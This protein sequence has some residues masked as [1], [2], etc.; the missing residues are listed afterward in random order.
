MRRTILATAIVFALLLGAPARATDVSGDQS[1]LWTLAGSPYLMVGDVR[2]PPGETL[3][4]EAGVEVIARG[5]YKLTVDNATLF[6]V[7]ADD[8]PI[9]MTAEDINAGWRGLRLESADDATTI[10]CCIIEYAKG[11]GDYPEV[12]GGAMMVRNCSPTIANNEI[13]YSSSHNG[14]Y[15]GTGGGICTETSSALILDNYIHDNIADSGGGVCITEYGSPIVWGNTIVDNTGSYAGGGMYFGARSSPFVEYNVLMRN[16]A[17]GWGG[18][19]INSWTSYIYNQTFAT[20]RNNLI[21]HN[22]ATDGGG[23]YC[24]YDRA[25][26]T[27][28][29]IA[30][31]SANSGGGMYVLNFPAQAPQVANSILWENTASNGPQ[32]HLYA[33]TGS[34]VSINYCDVEGGWAGTGNIDA[35]PAFVDPDGEDDQPGTDDDN[36]RLDAGSPC[37]DAGNNTALPPEVEEDLDGNPRFVDDPD[38]EDTGFGDPPIVDMGPYEYQAGIPGDIDGDGDVD[39]ADLLALL[40][41]WGD[42]EG[43]PEDI[44]GDG[45]VDT[46]DLLTL[47]ANW[48]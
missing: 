37:I 43:C 35:D 18:G 9:L 30:Y 8:L 10:R 32:V 42:C 25:V 20:I 27:N 12:R 44:D 29:V 5:H 36:L 1:G 17:G 26:I 16:H 24:R 45:D 4:I 21:A 46:T 15:N 3:T 11:T 41:A 7:G 48:G 34:A 19:G 33:D 47:L 28:N 6:A 23:L 13:R 39:T 40:A 22:T 31:N 38:T 14:N 2:V